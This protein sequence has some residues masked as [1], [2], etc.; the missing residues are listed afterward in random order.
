M[1]GNGMDWT[2]RAFLQNAPLCRALLSHA[3]KG[4]ASFHTPGHKG[5]ASPLCALGDLLKLDL[6][7]LP[8]TDSLF[9]ASGAIEEAQRAASERFGTK[10]TLFSAGGCTLAMQA[11]IGLA[12]GAG[13]KMI[14]GRNIHRAAVNAMALLGITPVWVQ[15]R[16]DAG[17]GLPGR[18]HPD[19]VAAALRLHPDAGAVYLTTPDYYGTLT[20]VRAI[21]EVC[22]KTHTPVIVDN[23]HGAH[24]RLCGKGLHPCDQGAAMAACSAHKTLPVMTGGAWLDIMDGRFV[25]NAQGMMALFGSTSPSYPIMASLDACRAWMEEG[26][27]AFARLCETAAEL[28]RFAESL[29]IGGPEGPSDPARLC[30]HTAQAGVSGEEAAE[31]FRRC[32]IEPEHEDGRYVVLLPSP[33]NPPEH[34]ERLKQ[35]LLTLPKGNPLPYE[36]HPVPL[37]EAAVTPREAVLSPGER[38]TVE[39]SAGR[40][41]AEAACPCPPGVPVV[42]PGEKIGKEQVCLLKRYGIEEIKVVK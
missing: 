2:N 13:G 15:P 10:R 34:F 16:P 30:L 40:I 18:V 28:R 38:A 19:D 42:M 36:P 3:A 41:A 17:E 31:H 8:D 39:N 23:A 35:A 27:E 7:E 24:L 5:E 37:P 21:A 1:R 26:Q 6:T 12:A 9:E 20:D 32:G 29:G 25:P 4:Q 11:M 14:A 22:R 33:F